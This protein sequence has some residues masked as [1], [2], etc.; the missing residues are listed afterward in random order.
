MKQIFKEWDNIPLPIK[1][2]LDK[3]SF[4]F[5]D[6]NTRLLSKARE[7]LLG[8]KYDFILHNGLWELFL[9]GSRKVE[10]EEV[11]I[12]EPIIVKKKK[13]KAYK[14]RKFSSRGP[15]GGRKAKYSES[16]SPIAFRL[17]ISLIPTVQSYVDDLLLKYAIENQKLITK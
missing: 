3:H 6:E 5:I 8:Y 15:G 10:V 11:K 4:A 16:T 1:T 17:P 13:R 7:E 12:V 9:I 2:V 14:K